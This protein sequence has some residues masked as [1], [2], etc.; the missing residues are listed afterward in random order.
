M[1]HNIGRR[2]IALLCLVALVALAVEP[3]GSS[4]LD[5]ANQA[6]RDQNW[7]RSAEYYKK[8]VEAQ[9]SDH[10]AWYNWACTLALSG[11]PELAAKTLLNAVEAGWRGRNHTERDPD[12]ETIRELA[13]Y[14]RALERIDE[15]LAEQAG[16]ES[17]LGLYTQQSRLSQ[18]WLRLPANYDPK[19]AYPLVILLHGRGHNPEGFISLADDLDT[20]NFIYAAPQAPNY[21]KDSRNGFQFYPSLSDDDSAT[22]TLAAEL[23]AEWIIQVSKDVG[24]R[25][26]TKGMK[27]W[28]AGFSQGGSVAHLMGMLRPDAVAGYAAL[29]GYIP[30]RF[31]SAERFEKMKQRGV[32]VFI[33]HGT[34]DEV[35]TPD[36]AQDALDTL[37]DYEI[38]V[39]Y[40]TYAVGHQVSDS[41]RVDLKAWLQR[42]A[43][44]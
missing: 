37:M 34:E 32:K 30:D 31:A 25:L 12:F 43:L 28:I 6:Y 21:I 17:I 4:Y 15:L 7:A 36:E 35:I 23:L 3:G 11:Q 41:M 33:G 9:P 8:W 18:Y 10:T 39:T 5:I 40:R 16:N 14:K 27:F 44:K 42:N 2:I 22:Y 24:E 38:D 19:K 13:D 26:K 1:A 20:L 29:G